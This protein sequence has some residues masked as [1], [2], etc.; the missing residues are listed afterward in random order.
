MSDPTYQ[1]ISK[2]KRQKESNNVDGAIKTLEDF[3][4]DEPYNVKVRLLLSNIAIYDLEDLDYGMLQLDT[5]L[6]LEPEN[7]DALKA[8][9]TF[10]MKYKKY[11]KKTDEN[12]QKLLSLCPDAELYNTY[13]VFLKM[14][15][16]DF[17]RA[18]EYY[19]KAIKLDPNKYEYHQNYAVL[20]L[21]D[22]RDYIKAKEELE[23]V[24]KLNPGN[25]TVSKNY[26][27]LLK[28]KFDKDGNLKKKKMS[29]M[30]R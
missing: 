18:A 19:E 10:M 23:T 3:L 21:N 2:A 8:S 22:L 16:T 28:R 1:V 27:L 29:F 9:V 30:K 13:A 15:L 24:L 4:Y 12:Y 11:N 17:E 25:F 7:T 20:L 14:Q 6:D 5:I 26:D